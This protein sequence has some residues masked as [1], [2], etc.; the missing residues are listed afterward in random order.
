MTFEELYYRAMK[1][2]EL[3]RV[4]KSNKQ[5]NI[6]L[7]G[8]AKRCQEELDRRQALQNENLSL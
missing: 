6:G 3:I 2:H 1:D 5:D 8:Y 4:I 7:D